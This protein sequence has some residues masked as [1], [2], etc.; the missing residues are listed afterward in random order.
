MMVLKKLK[1]GT[2]I[3]FVNINKS[4]F[5]GTV[6][7]IIGANFVVRMSLTQAA[8]V[9]NK[10]GTKV[11]YLVGFDTEAFRCASF[12]MDV[13]TNKDYETI[14]L[15]MPEVIMVVER[16][17]FVRLKAILPVSY[18]LMHKT[19]FYREIKDVPPGYWKK[20]KSSFTIDIGGGGVS[21]ITYEN[22]D[23]AQCA[24]LRLTLSQDIK[25]L[26]SVVRSIG[27]AKDDTYATAF[28]FE[29]INE[30][31]RVAIIRYVNERTE[32]GN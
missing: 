14:V 20:T 21:L 17:Q 3:N 15:T 27:N 24:L 22:S 18:Y 8:F 12:V 28:K 1:I 29:D 13:K 10:K 31:S 9:S 5:D 2:V 4:I 26:C 11:D 7:A 25:V 32:G 30:E 23:I 6:T 19:E 16:R